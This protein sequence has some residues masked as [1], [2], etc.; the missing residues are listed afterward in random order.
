M[1]LTQLKEGEKCK[2]VDTHGGRGMIKKL[3]ALGIR[4]G[5]KIIKINSQFMRGPIVVKVGNTSVAVGYGIAEK[6]IVE[7]ISQQKK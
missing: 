3:D 5:I 4:T 7:P 6:I 1:N 2:V